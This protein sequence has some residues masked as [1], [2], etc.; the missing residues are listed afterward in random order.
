MQAARGGSKAAQSLWQLYVQQR[1][2]SIGSSL[3]SSKNLWDV[4]NRQRM[5]PH[6]AEAVRDI[7]MEVRPAAWACSPAPLLV[8]EGAAARPVRFRGRTAAGARAHSWVR[9]H[10]VRRLPPAFFTHCP[11][12]YLPGCHPH[13][14]SSMPTPPRTA[15]PRG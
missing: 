11:P 6:G 15:L 3:P 8:L 9:H 2:H 13:P 4:V 5:E 7:W 14:R 12:P 1:G 10:A